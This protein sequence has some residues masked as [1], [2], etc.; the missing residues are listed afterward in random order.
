[1]GEIKV[2]NMGI[3]SFAQA[4]NEQGVTMIHVDWKPPAGGDA[5]LME[6]LKKMK[7]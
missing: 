3:P 6:L 7:R 4:L 1:P 2:I 5:R